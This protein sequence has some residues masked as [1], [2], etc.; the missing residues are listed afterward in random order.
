MILILLLSLIPITVFAIPTEHGLLRNKLVTTSAF[1]TNPNFATDNSGSTSATLNQN[2]FLRYVLDKEY[3]ISSYYLFSSTS[4]RIEFIDKNGSVIQ[5][6]QRTTANP[7]DVRNNVNINGVKEIIVKNTI[8][9]SQSVW[10][11]DVY[12]TPSVQSDYPI[13][14]L[15]GKADTFGRTEATDGNN[16][17]FLRTSNSI[18]SND[19]YKRAIYHLEGYYDITQFYINSQLLTS[20][21]TVRFIRDGTLVASHTFNQ[22]HNGNINIEAIRINQVEIG[23][24]SATQQ[25]NLYSIEVY[26]T[27]TPVALTHNYDLT[28]VTNRPTDSQINTFIN[29]YLYVY[30][31]RATMSNTDTT[32]GLWILGS[33][34]PIN[35]EENIPQD[36]LYHISDTSI[37][38]LSPTGT[39]TNVGSISFTA[40][41]STRQLTTEIGSPNTAGIYYTYAPPE[42]PPQHEY[43]LSGITARATDEQINAFIAQYPY[44]LPLRFNNQLRIYGSHSPITA[45]Y[46][47]V[48]DRYTIEANRNDFFRLNADGSTTRDDI[49]FFTNLSTDFEIFTTEIGEPNTAGIYYT[50][51]PPEPIELQPIIVEVERLG[52]YLV[53]IFWNEQPNI[54]EYEIRV[55]DVKLASTKGTSYT[56]TFYREN[57]YYPI[58]I[59]ATSTD[60]QVIYSDVLNYKLEFRPKRPELKKMQPSSNSVHLEWEEVPFANKY[61]VYMIVTNT[62]DYSPDKMMVNAGEGAAPAANE[63]LLIETTDT[64][65]TVE[66]LEEG[67]FYSFQ[68]AAVNDV[69]ES[70]R[71][72]V[73]II[74]SE[75]AISPVNIGFRPVDIII[76]AIVILGS[77]ASFVLLGLSMYYLPRVI[78][79]VKNAAK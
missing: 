65:Y 78:D 9:S 8:T 19:L 61:R 14:L 41:L 17:T 73:N 54:E 79:I 18:Q 69:G 26:G 39:E 70:S 28:G 21:Y 16:T 66:G 62:A 50:Y 72:T 67:K 43:N 12:G 32:L 2:G 51:S 29:K 48:L 4:I 68:I 27:K 75:N 56:A 63:Q 77:L 37:Y 33:N 35:I 52:D 34:T 30:P 42:P 6:L 20:N 55:H 31:I 3:D 53:R 58:Q 57:Q 71:L 1:T 60:G 38:T 74:A 7:D 15:Y 44:V 76:N 5:T 59:K 47:P 46:N 40:N 36:R 23:A 10:E 13:G 25:N 45:S 11:V 22:S 24:S 64:S 49:F